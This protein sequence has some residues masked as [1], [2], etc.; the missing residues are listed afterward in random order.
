MEDAQIIELFWSRSEAAVQAAAKKYGRLL[1]HIA[2]NI[3]AN[4]EDSEE[5]VNDVFFQAWQTIPPQHPV[6]LTAYLGRL[7]R[8]RSINRWHEKHA[9]KRYAGT[10]ILLS[11]LAECIPSVDSV[12]QETDA[13]ELSAFISEWLSLQ[14]N[15]NRILFLR[16]YWFGDSVKTLSR[17]TGTATN[18]LAA[19]L[20][21]LRQKLKKAMEKE[22]IRP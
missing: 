14:T 3:L 10:E 22:G 21:R 11:E 1:Y 2:Y 6:S 13:H 9:Q 15:D 18:K 8:N 16:R 7:V 17:Q 5:C 12:E 4:H 19:R 20:Y